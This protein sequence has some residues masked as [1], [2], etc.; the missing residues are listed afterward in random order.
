MNNKKYNKLIIYTFISIVFI[1]STLNYVIDPYAV[2]NKTNFLNK[3]KPCID[4]NHRFS[5]IP[6]FKIFNKNV[7]A[8]WAGSSKTWEG[9]NEEYESKTLGGNV[10]N[11]A[12]SSCTFDEAIIMA[13]NA[14]ILHPEIKTIYFG[15]DFFRFQKT[16]NPETE[17]LKPVKSLAIEKEELFPLILSLSTFDDSIKTILKNL[18]VIFK[19][20]EDIQ[21][22]YGFERNY[23]KRI[24]HRFQASISKY[25]KEFYQNYNLDDKKFEKLQEFVEYAETKRIEVVIFTTTMHAA[26]RTL[27]YNTNNFQN[28]YKFKEKL[29]EIQPYYDFALINEYTTEEI[30][31]DI[32]N[33]RDAVHPLPHIR[34]KMTDKLF[35]N[36]GDFGLYI[37][38]NN[39]KEINEKDNINFQNYIKENPKII[40][41]VKEWSR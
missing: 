24:F 5:K 4:K 34:K 12:I 33:W 21:P 18:K 41:Q 19:D 2:F 20:K 40:E 14:I 30:K 23:N 37:T 35:L 17:Q 27:I 29:A 3:E 15:V 11:L 32:Q 25:Y 6:A 36:N 8:I 22:E 26:E 28:F 10:K 13:K 38:K 7:T 9:S 31:P 1:V 39:V 16:I